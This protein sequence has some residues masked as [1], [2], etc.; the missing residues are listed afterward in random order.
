MRRLANQVQ[1]V[2]IVYATSR[3]NWG[4]IGPCLL[5]LVLWI[6]LLDDSQE[7][8]DGK[9]T[10]D[11]MI[12][13]LFNAPY[14]A[15][16]Y[17]QIR[18]QFMHPRAKLLPNF[19]AAHWIVAFA[20]CVLIGFLLPTAV[21]LLSNTSLLP[22]YAIASI[23]SAVS[24][25][26]LVFPSAYWVF[27][28]AFFG[29]QFLGYDPLRLEFVESPAICASIVAVA[30]LGLVVCGYWIATLGEDD[31]AYQHAVNSTRKVEADG[32]DGQTQEQFK[33]YARWSFLSDR[34]QSGVGGFHQFRRWRIIRLLRYGFWAKPIEVEA[35]G[36]ALLMTVAVAWLVP[37]TDDAYD[38]TCSTDYVYLIV[39]A[40]FAALAPIAVA[41]SAMGLR[42]PRLKNEILFP[43]TRH[44]LFDDLL[45]ATA[46]YSLLIWLLG[47]L[48]GMAILLY[49]LPDEAKSVSLF[50]TAAILTASTAIAAYGLSLHIVMWEAKPAQF[51]VLAFFVIGF[52]TLIC[53]WWIS[54]EKSGDALYWIIAMIV[55]GVGGITIHTARK[56][57]L[58]LE[59]G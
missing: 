6:V 18:Q 26:L 8:S 42:V 56:A 23:V 34:W 35:V 57:W 27:L 14:A 55:S 13:L 19:Y 20:I 7:R 17:D 4:W 52:V 21:A 51:C 58:N 33:K 1:Q 38:L 53:T 12:L 24:M 32:S 9:L 5:F 16:V 29:S 49:I 40:L 59:L 2:A 11:W 50:A 39:P 31:S 44:Q 28:I 54:R 25:L 48:S 41:G 3:G 45:L 36:Y 37:K 47:C 22:M 43:L 30:W 15:F 10:T 46:W